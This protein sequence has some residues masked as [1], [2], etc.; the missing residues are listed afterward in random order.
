[1]LCG[2]L[3]SKTRP[4]AMNADAC[5][6]PEAGVPEQRRAIQQFVHRFLS[7][8]HVVH[9]KKGEQELSAR[10]GVS[11]KDFQFSFEVLVEC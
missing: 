7:I 11:S 3:E 10:F 1:M 5:S 8:G 2:E 6:A 9:G 4:R